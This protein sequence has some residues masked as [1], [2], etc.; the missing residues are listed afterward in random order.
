M[1]NSKNYPN[2]RNYIG[3]PGLKTLLETLKT[4]SNLNTLELELSEYIY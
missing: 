4:M 1:L 3:D 2:F